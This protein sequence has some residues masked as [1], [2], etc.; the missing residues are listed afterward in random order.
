M[1]SSRIQKMGVLLSTKM[2]AGENA[3]TYALRFQSKLDEC[4]DAGLEFKDETMIAWFLNTLTADYKDFTRTQARSSEVNLTNVLTSFRR[5]NTCQ[6][7]STSH[8][9]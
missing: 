1:A 7:P 9:S 3:E 5:S 8:G 2:N 4:K 6:N